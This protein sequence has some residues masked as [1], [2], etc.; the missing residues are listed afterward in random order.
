MSSSSFILALF[1]GLTCLSPSVSAA[2]G[3]VV[4]NSTTPTNIVSSSSEATLSLLDPFYFQKNIQAA[5]SEDTLG[6]EV[7]DPTIGTKEAI[8]TVTLNIKNPVTKEQIQVKLAETDR[9]SFVFRG[10]VQAIHDIT[11]KAENTIFVSN[12]ETLEF[13]YKALKKTLPIIGKAQ[14]QLSPTR[15]YFH[16]KNGANVDTPA[17]TDLVELLPGTTQEKQLL[18]TNIGDDEAYYVFW[19]EDFYKD[20]FDNVRYYTDATAPEGL[21]GVALSKWLKV[22][23][24]QRI[25]LKSKE[26]KSLKLRLNIPAGAAPG[27]MYSAFI[28]KQDVD[29]G[30]QTTETLLTN[31]EYS[32]LL[33]ANIGAQEALVLSGKAEGIRV[34]D[35]SDSKSSKSGFF[36]G[37][38]GTGETLPIGVGFDFLNTGNAAFK[39]QGKVTLNNVFRMNVITNTLSFP[40]SAFP[41]IKK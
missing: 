18:I 25:L 16:L 8:D 20:E 40:S 32:V 4:P 30:L 12:R 3:T 29:S 26:T 33:A 24:P 38:S 5:T 10:T 34:F 9:E 35:P 28:I 31:Q 36:F 2:T 6:L 19:F 41:K 1:V 27:G 13:T 39:P 21:K 37:S 14:L 7:Y 17:S 23:G 22:D 11:K 15:L